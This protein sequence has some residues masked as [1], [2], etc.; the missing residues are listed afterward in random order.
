[1][2]VHNNKKNIIKMINSLMILCVLV[3]M[4]C[5]NKR[6]IIADKIIRGDIITLDEK[7]PT[8][9]VVACKNG[10][11]IYVGSIFGAQEYVDFD[12]EEINFDS[13]PIYPGFIDMHSNGVLYGFERFSHLSLSSGENYD[14][15]I[16]ILKKYIAE[17]PGKKYYIA[18][19]FK[20]FDKEP[21]HE[22]LDKVSKEVP[23]IVHS[24]IGHCFLLNKVAMALININVDTVNEYLSGDVIT[25]EN[26]EPTGLLYRTAINKI[27]KEFPFD[28]DSI[29]EII[30]NWQDIALSRGYVGVFKSEER[31]FSDMQECAYEELRKNG[32]IKLKTFSYVP[33]E[34]DLDMIENNIEKNINKAKSS[35]NELN[36]TIGVKIFIDSGINTET[37]FLINENIEDTNNNLK[38]L[39]NLDMMVRFI[40][41]I[42]KY[43]MNVY[44]Y[45]LSEQ[46]TN[47]FI[48]CV[49]EAKERSDNISRKN[50]ISFK[51]N[52]SLSNYI[53]NKN[54][55]GMIDE[56]VF[57]PIDGKVFLNEEN[58]DLIDKDIYEFN[59]LNNADVLTSYYTHYPILPI[60]EIPYNLFLRTHV[61]D[62][63]MDDENIRKLQKNALISYTKGVANF[64]CAEK[65]YGTIEVGKRADFTVFSSN[66]LN[67]VLVFNNM[68]QEPVATIIGGEIA[69]SRDE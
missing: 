35:D 49:K 46:A 44:V 28:I 20:I 6:H 48:K 32:Q 63:N 25:F 62:N 13:Q 18:T 3:L 43:N 10:K 69:Y 39:I 47:F 24:N 4:S 59:L 60:L 54:H 15:Y 50:M 2:V 33:I 31:L 26:G 51:K 22:L 11:V 1:M 65:D 23:V 27:V 45:S 7:N 37:C 68:E 14:D 29:K 61:S 34:S 38:Y 12:T 57:I 5:N 55:E 9:S 42:S 8:A 41:L 21:T 36:K 52:G 40:E 17:N 16:N 66:F 19:D 30:L 53:K 56:I 58:G 67:E 64:L